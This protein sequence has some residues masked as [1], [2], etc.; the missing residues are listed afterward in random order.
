MT[1]EKFG[2]TEDGK[3]YDLRRRPL[4]LNDDSLPNDSVVRV[5]PFVS[6]RELEDGT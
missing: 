1:R 2:I 4:K 6:S 5:P 3:V